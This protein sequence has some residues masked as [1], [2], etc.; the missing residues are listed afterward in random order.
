MCRSADPLSGPEYPSKPTDGKRHSPKVRSAYGAKGYFWR[1]KQKNMSGKETVKLKGSEVLLSGYIPELKEV[2]PDFTFVM[3]DLSE[4]SLYDFEGLNKVILSVP[5]IDTGI[6]AL[7]TKKFNEKLAKMDNVVCLVVSKDLPFAMKRFCAAEGIENVKPASDFRY[8]DFGKE[9]NLE[10]VNSPLKG[11][12]ARA[13]FV[14]NKEN[15]IVHVELVAD[16]TYEPDYDKAL[17]A[18]AKLA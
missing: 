12:L 5:S 9:Y 8:G 6:C 13:V 17:A 10:M 18:L 16:I 4:K 7:E 11:L 1:F 3:Q 14:L 2:A 15:R